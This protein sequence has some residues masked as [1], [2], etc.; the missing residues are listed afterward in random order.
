MSGAFTSTGMLTNNGLQLLNIDKY[1]YKK[2]KGLTIHI[3]PLSLDKKVNVVR[4]ISTVIKVFTPVIFNPS[5]THIAIQLFLEDCDDIL[6]FEYGQYYSNKSD[7]KKSIFSSSSNSSNE[8][9]ESNNE[10]IYYYIN[11]DGARIT[12]F[13][14]DYLKKFEN[15]EPGDKFYDDDK[16]SGLIT[17]LIERQHYNISYDECTKNYSDYYQ[18]G[19]SFETVDC[20]VINKITVRELRDHFKG[21]KWLAKKYNVAFHNCQTFGAEIIKKLKA[22]RINEKDKVRANEKVTLPGCIIS[23]LWHNEKLSLTNTLGRIPIFGLFHDF[24]LAAHDKA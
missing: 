17:I 19:N 14:I 12:V 10:N 8:P 16:I 23:S 3:I 21:E 1:L 15:I 6:I 18:F 24:Y 20:E 22:I 13:T 4:G 11:T 2:I 9:R 7:S 5:L